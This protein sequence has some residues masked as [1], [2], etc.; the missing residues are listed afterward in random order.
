MRYQLLTEFESLF[1]GCKY[2]HRRS[3]LGD[4][5][6][7]H[8]YE[9]L[10][11][12]GRSN[13][14]VERVREGSRVVTGANRV[15]GISARR[16]DGTFGEA[17]PDE[18]P[19]FDPNYAVGRGPTATIEIGVE[20]K[21]VAKAMIKQIDRVCSDLRNQANQFRS[22]GGQPITVAIVGINHAAKYQSFEGNRT[23]PTS[24]KSGRLHPVQE[25]R[26]AEHRLRRDAEPAF[27]HFLLLRFKASNYEPFPFEWLNTSETKRD[28]GAILV[29]ISAEYDRRF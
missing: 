6:A 14:F 21:I 9:D 11:R 25:A 27:D 1:K 2:N 5:V 15:H 29:R 17:L 19:V 16:G 4:W 24:G 12:L 13:K 18:V 22:A 10:A 3:N 23:Y 28:Y 8:L 20:V 26:E 7:I